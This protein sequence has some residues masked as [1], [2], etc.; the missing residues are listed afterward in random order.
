MSSPSSAASVVAD[1]EQ[2]ALP[3]AEG[4]THLG[5]RLGD[6]RLSEAEWQGL[7]PQSQFQVTRL[8]ATEPAKLKFPQ[9]FDDHFDSGIY[10]CSC[11][12]VAGKCAPLYTSKMKFECGCGWPGFW[13]NVRDAVYE[14]RDADGRRCEIMCARCDSHLGHIFRG[15]PFG[16]CTKERHCVNSLSIVFAAAGSDLSMSER[17][18]GPDLSP[19]GQR[20]EVVGGVE[21]GG[22]VVRVG[23]ELSSAQESFRLSSG[24]W[25]E[26]IELAAGRLHY[27]L[28]KGTGPARGWVS[29]KLAGKEL[30]IKIQ[31]LPSSATL[32]SKISFVTPTFAGKVH[33]PKPPSSSETASLP[34]QL[35]AMVHELKK[36]G[37]PVDETDPEQVRKILRIL[38]EAKQ[39]TK[40]RLVS[41]E[42]AMPGR[43]E[44]LAVPARHHV[45]GTPLQGPWPREYQVLIVANGCFWGSEKGMWRLPGIHST[46]VGY[47]GGYTPNPTYEEVCSGRTGHTEAVQV[48]FDPSRIGLVDILTW[49]W[50]AHDPT[51][52]MGQGN[53]RGTQYRSALYYFDDAHRGLLEG[54]K[55]AYESALKAQGKGKGERITTEI[56][57]ASDFPQSRV[58]YFAEAYHQQY[59]AKPGARPYCS[60]QPQGVDLPSWES[61]APASCRPK[62]PTE[63]WEIHRPTPHCV[64]NAPDEPISWA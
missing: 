25:I 44:P 50:Q 12:A 28:L 24:A 36:A 11:C 59:L 16:F 39:Q 29:I 42:E 20:W 49:F 6:V 32:D 56:R 7:L 17:V 58:F 61:W 30:V 53:D 55:A 41:K 38:K 14:Q 33:L 37:V 10:F 54:S 63:F 64:I 43:A 5:A 34:P 8:K 52:G 3:L 27:K 57:A 22:I 9:G 40:E 48:V 47:A 21:S 4:V 31:A 62:L 51:Q 35:L 46:A 23:R 13:T 19:R 18:A 2:Y 26:E 1:P 15:E 60:A 45:L